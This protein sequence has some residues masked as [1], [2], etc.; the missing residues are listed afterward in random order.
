M[1]TT[2]TPAGR[3]I[4]DAD[5]HIMEVRDWL[6]EYADP[7]IRERLR[8]LHLGGAGGRVA[9]K[10][11]DAAEAR[12]GDEA[13]ANALEEKL[14]TAKGWGALGAFDPD[15]R[16]RAL[17]LLGLGSTC[18]RRSPAPSSPETTSSCST[19]APAR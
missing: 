3:T 6:S 15:E 14:M 4:F 2:Y 17:D 8:P 10:A 13:A 1:T 11:V 9:E 16:S 12:R 5:S 19:G 18:S 7:G